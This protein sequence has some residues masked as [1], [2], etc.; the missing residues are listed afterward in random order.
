MTLFKDMVWKE[1]CSDVQRTTLNK[2]SFVLLAFD[3]HT[4]KDIT[5]NTK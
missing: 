4:K 3:L 1:V 5:T 2:L